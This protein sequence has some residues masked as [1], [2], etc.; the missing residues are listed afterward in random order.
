MMSL[1]ISSNMITPNLATVFP[2]I[3]S[4]HDNMFTINPFNS[5][6]IA[7]D[8][9]DVALI[10]STCDVGEYN[11]VQSIAQGYQCTACPAGSYQYLQ[12]QTSCIA[13]CAPG[14]Y[15]VLSGQSDPGTCVLCPPGTQNPVYS[16]SSPS[17][18]VQCPAGS[19]SAVVGTAV[20]PLCA[21]GSYQN[22]T[23]QFNCI[24]CIEGNMDHNQ[25]Q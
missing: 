11:T 17:A 21:A 10:D 23:G 13:A 12:G 18:C 6:V 2:S 5:R 24:L 4:G 25:A 22:S 20:C 16:S 8:K 7:I 3:L 19:S 1:N 14:S 15:G 9:S